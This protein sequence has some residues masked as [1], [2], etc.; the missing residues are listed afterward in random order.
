VG[1]VGTGVVVLTL[2]FFSIPPA[3]DVHWT[4]LI[5]EGSVLAMP[6]CSKACILLST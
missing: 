5:V 3:I 1:V 6:K 4:A 2:M